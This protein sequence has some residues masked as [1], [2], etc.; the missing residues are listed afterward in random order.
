MSS[1]EP[2]RYTWTKSGQPLTGNNVIINDNVVIVT[3]RAKEDY[4]VH[5][6]KATNSAGSAEYEI[7]LKE[8]KKSSTDRDSAK[9]GEGNCCHSSIQVFPYLFFLFLLRF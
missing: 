5:V 3:P 6:C 7:T 4:G 1:D 2:V 8:E 9:G